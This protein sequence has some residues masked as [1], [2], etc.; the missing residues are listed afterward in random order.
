[1]RSRSGSPSRCGA[2]ALAATTRIPA[3]WVLVGLAV[4]IWG[5]WPRLSG[6]VW[7]LFVAFLVMGEFGVLWDI[8]EWVRTLSPFAH[9]PVVPGPDPSY[10]GIPVMLVSAGGLVA[11][12]IARFA[13]RD[14]VSA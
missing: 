6:A 12:G 11:L 1:M 7:V 2:S 4:A 8:P 10:L 9:S 3:A 14:V 5:F 13:R